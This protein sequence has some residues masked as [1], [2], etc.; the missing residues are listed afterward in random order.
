MQKLHG[1]I[2]LGYGGK[3]G[4]NDT[5]S[6]ASRSDNG[7]FFIKS[8]KNSEKTTYGD[9]SFLASNI[10]MNSDSITM[11]ANSQS[12][13]TVD[14]SNISMNSENIITSSYATRMVASTT[15]TMDAAVD[16]TGDVDISGYVKLDKAA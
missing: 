2:T 12:Y 14:S 10:T 6:L 7:K 4:G 16:I 11:D 5:T 13:I 8:F 9:L 15:I 3:V 1:E